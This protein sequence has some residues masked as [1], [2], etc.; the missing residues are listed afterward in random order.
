[1]QYHPFFLVY[2]LHPATLSFLLY[3]VLPK[4]E[5]QGIARFGSTIIAIGYD[6]RDVT[7]ISIRYIPV[8]YILCRSWY[9]VQYVMCLFIGINEYKYFLGLWTAHLCNDFSTMSSN[10]LCVSLSRQSSNETVAA[11]TVSMQSLQQ[12]TLV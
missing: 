11:A 2:K 8:Q 3:L 5:I 12:Q 10:S 9:E 4:Q 7:P 6:P 1:M